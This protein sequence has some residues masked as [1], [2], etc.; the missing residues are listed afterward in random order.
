M[1]FDHIRMNILEMNGVGEARE[2]KLKGSKAEFWIILKK[3]KK[4][5]KVKIQCRLRLI[6]KSYCIFN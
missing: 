3:K 1:A 4:K 2:M 5:K 6:Q